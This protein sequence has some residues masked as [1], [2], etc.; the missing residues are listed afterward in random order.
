VSEDSKAPQSSETEPVPQSLLW[1]FDHD[2]HPGHRTDTTLDLQPG[3]AG[4][5]PLTV[6]VRGYQDFMSNS[7]YLA[8]FV[9]NA[10]HNLA[11]CLRLILSVETLLTVFDGVT[12]I[13]SNPCVGDPPQSSDD[14]RFTG[15]LYLY[16]D[17]VLNDADRSEISALASQRGI[18][19]HVRDA[20]YAASRT[21]MTKPDAFVCHDSRDKE[22]VV[23]PLVA[24]LQKR[25]VHLWYDEFSLRIGDALRESVE[26]GLM[27]SRRC[28]LLVSKN[29]LQN[30]GW[31]SNEF[32]AIFARETSEGAKLILPV[33]HLVSA[34][35]VMAYSPILKSRFAGRTDE[36]ME[37]VAA[38]LAD[39]LQNARAG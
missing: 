27:E 34:D 17:N 14:L 22:S 16:V 8:C 2:V 31:T 33:W 29:F 1:Y 20:A 25:G 38:K 13:Q 35:E 26:R 19:V 11:A 37:T 10:P 4:V 3:Q 12:M 28:I 6:R 7:K 24:A 21:T 5:V 18:H 36:G 39:L 15:R 30:E 32:D 9:P 23:R